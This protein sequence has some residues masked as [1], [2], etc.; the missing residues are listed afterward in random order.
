MN[1]AGAEN[2]RPPERLS[3]PPS[4]AASAASSVGRGVRDGVRAGPEAAPVPLG[5]VLQHAEVLRV[6]GG[7]GGRRLGVAVMQEQRVHEAGT[8]PHV[9]AKTTDAVAR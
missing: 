6:A 7:G 2:T 1:G 9:G 8:R 3:E 5:A 4:S